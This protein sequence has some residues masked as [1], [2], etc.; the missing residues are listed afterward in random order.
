LLF[1]HPERGDYDAGYIDL[2]LTR[3]VI[4]RWD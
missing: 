4:V 1:R 3:E 2:T